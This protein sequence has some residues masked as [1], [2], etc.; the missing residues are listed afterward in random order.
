[1][2]EV[3]Q[4]MIVRSIRDL[5]VLGSRSSGNSLRVFHDL[6]RPVAAGRDDD[7]VHVRVAAGDLLE[8]CLAGAEWTGNAVGTA[9]G[10]GEEGVDQ[11]H[12]GDHGIHGLEPFA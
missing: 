8:D 7:D 2:E 10:D 12:A 11:A 4:M 1:M 3:L 5:P 6:A 9:P